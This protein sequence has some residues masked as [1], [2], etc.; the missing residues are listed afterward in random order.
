MTS[1]FTYWMIWN[2]LTVVQGQVK[3]WWPV[4]WSSDF[5]NRQDQISDL[6]CPL[7]DW[8]P[9][10]ACI[11]RSSLGFDICFITLSNCF[12][13]PP[14]SD[15]DLWS[16]IQYTNSSFLLCQ[17][18]CLFLVTHPWECYCQRS[19]GAHFR[20]RSAGSGS[21]DWG[22]G[23][24]S[25]LSLISAPASLLTCVVSLGVCW[26]SPPRAKSISI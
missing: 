5:Q 8:S 18:V 25:L 16:V 19:H 17:W 1:C 6:C 20:C 9:G 22:C 15:F 14:P 12:S 2:A 24:W 23:H 10:P 13:F 3:S 7:A 11:S 26:L 4:L 21:E